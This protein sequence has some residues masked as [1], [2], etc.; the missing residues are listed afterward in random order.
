MDSGSHV[1]LQFID[2]QLNFF[3]WKKSAHGVSRNCVANAPAGTLV[4]CSGVLHQQEV[5]NMS[6]DVQ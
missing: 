5:K 2:G 4:A 1:V 3:I 6:L